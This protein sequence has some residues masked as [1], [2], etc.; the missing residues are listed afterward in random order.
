MT[1]THKKISVKFKTK[2]EENTKINALA[3]RKD[4]GT[5]RYLKD[6]SMA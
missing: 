2:E 6:K 3:R 5:K 4:Y 1:K